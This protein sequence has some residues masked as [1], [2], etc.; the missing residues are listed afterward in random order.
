MGPRLRWT[1]LRLLTAPSLLAVVG[2][3]TIIVVQRG[4]ADW[5]ISD[6]LVSLAFVSLLVTISLGFSALGFTGDQVVLPLIA[7]LGCLGLLSIQ[8]LQPDLAAATPH[9]G[10]LAQRQVLFLGA[11]LLTVWLTVMLGRIEWLHR[12]KY[13]WLLLT[14]AL[15][16]ITFLFGQEI[17]GARLWLAIGPLQFQ[18][19]ELAKLTLVTFMAG[20]L[21]DRREL[22]AQP[23]RVGR[24]RLPPVPVLLPLALVWAGALAVLIV[25]N[26]LGSALLFFGLFVIMLY[27]ATGSAGYVAVGLVAFA[28][29]SW[30]ASLLFARLAVRIQNWL[31][32]WQ[33]PLGAGFQQVQSEYA[34]A[35]GGLFG[36]GLGRGRPTLIPEVQ[37]DF[38]L[39]ALGEEL[40][41]AGLLAILGCY[42]LLLMRCYAIALRSGDSFG[43]LVA[44][45]LG[46][47]VAL[48]ALIIVGGVVRLIPL[49]GLTLPFVSYGGSSLLANCLAVGF[50]LRIS[51]DVA[52]R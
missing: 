38:V 22:L 45:G 26:D 46:S 49:T 17:N 40:G 44:V 30:L 33:D 12:Y 21:T 34:L 36:T 5:S 47:A 8:R 28:A 37:T 1:E 35:S 27:V 3:L 6:I 25:Q 16:L 13:T 19:S 42:V 11:G 7:V 2:L 52:Q 15:L 14:L 29:G 31:D 41:L 9:L 10:G 43:Q 20:Y 23:W 18:P 32:P 39:S 4:E 24:L 50:L 51:G 48:Q